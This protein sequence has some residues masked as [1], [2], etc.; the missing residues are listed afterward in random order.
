MF[1]FPKN[2]VFPVKNYGNEMML[3]DGVNILALLAL[4]Q[5]ICFAE[6]YL[7]NQSSD[8]EDCP[9]KDQKHDFEAGSESI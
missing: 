2:H 5:I 8:N 4:R 7:E 3:D 9:V 6:D 1:G